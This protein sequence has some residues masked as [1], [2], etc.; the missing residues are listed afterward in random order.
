MMLS[1]TILHVLTK[2]QLIN[3]LYIKH[4]WR[5]SYISYELTFHVFHMN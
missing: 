1:K 4:A 3:L 5:V 2:F